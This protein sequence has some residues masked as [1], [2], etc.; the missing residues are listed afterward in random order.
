MGDD[1]E[2]LAITPAFSLANVIDFRTD[3]LNIGLIKSGGALNKV[4]VASLEGG[5]AGTLKRYIQRI[6]PKPAPAG[7]TMLVMVIKDLRVSENVSF[8]REAARL[9]V[10][11]EFYNLGAK[12]MPL[13]FSFSRDFQLLGFDVTP[14][15]ETNIRRSIRAALEELVAASAK[16]TLTAHR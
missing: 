10:K 16:G 12:D 8:F 6:L 1:D 15:H 3:T 9:H 4:E 2:P 11:Y 13:V 5:C 14:R 7:K